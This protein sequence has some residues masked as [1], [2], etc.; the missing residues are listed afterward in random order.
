MSIVSNGEVF[1]ISVT[2]D[3]EGTARNISEWNKINFWRRNGKKI[4]KEN[5]ILRPTYI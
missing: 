1:I 3:T 5:E 4:K 2:P